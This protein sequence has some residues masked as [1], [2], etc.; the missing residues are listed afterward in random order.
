VTDADV[1]P[2]TLADI[3]DVA[4]LHAA[5]DR[6]LRGEFRTSREELAAHWPAGGGWIVPGAGYSAVDR[7]GEL[8]LCVV[9]SPR[10]PAVAATLTAAATAGHPEP[11]E[12]VVDAVDEAAVTALTGA[13]FALEHEVIE[14]TRELETP[15]RPPA[16]PPGVT[17]R[18]FDE[19]Q[20]AHAV[21]A[22]LVAAFAGSHESVMPFERWRPWLTSDP[23]Y[24]P[25]VVIVAQAGD[26]VAGVA[27]CWV[28]GWV[29]DLAV[30]PD[31]R[32]RGLGEALMREA[33]VRLA[34]RGVRRC[35]LKVDADNPTGAPRLYARLG[36]AELRRHAVYGRGAAVPGAYS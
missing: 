3:D 35:G 30:M 32:G 5:R 12:A 6:A 22:C 23:A 19:E 25:E 17:L 29:K 24:D 36:M 18:S 11:L 28:D 21:H 13:G 34:A 26:A 31:Q 2:A 7:D 4:A 9:P 20:D 8:R 16:V 15:E 10:A 14:M 27:Q 33:F 1:Q